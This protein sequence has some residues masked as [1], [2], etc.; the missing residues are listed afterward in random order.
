VD[1]NGIF[2]SRHV[3]N[4]SIVRNDF[5]AIGE[6]AIAVVGATGKHRT[7]NAKN[8]DYPAFNLIEA[9]HANVVGVWNKQSAAYFKSVARANTVRNNVFHDGPRSA[10]NWNDGFAGVV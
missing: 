7:N 4:C 9:N 1:G 8:L 6:T 5:D 2:L 3:R 10:I